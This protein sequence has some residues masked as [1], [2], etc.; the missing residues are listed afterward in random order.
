MA[1]DTKKLILQQPD[2]VGDYIAE[3]GERCPFCDEGVPEDVG[4]S[5]TAGSSETP[6]FKKCP[7]CERVWYEL[8]TLDR[9]EDDAGRR[10][11]PEGL[12]R[13]RTTGGCPFCNDAFR[14]TTWDE[15]RTSNSTEMRLVTTEQCNACN[16]HYSV[17]QVLTDL[18]LNPEEGIAGPGTFSSN[19]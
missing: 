3:Q 11:G 2:R 15:Y 16:H 6:I 8:Y 14:Q 5:Q 10:L 4:D 18:D 7:D 12:E 13:R 19:K 9:I 1:K 17:V